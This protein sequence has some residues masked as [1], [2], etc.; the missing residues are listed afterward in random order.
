MRSIL[1]NMLLL[2]PNRFLLCYEEVL[3]FLLFFEW[4]A[5]FRNN[6]CRLVGFNLK[7][8]AVFI[9]DF[10]HFFGS[11]NSLFFFSFTK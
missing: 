11:L 7:V 2:E 6:L 3:G 10:I 5:L 1:H 9:C 8:N 4:S